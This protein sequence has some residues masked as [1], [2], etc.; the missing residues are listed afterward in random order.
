MKK[1]FFCFVSLA[2][3]CV[4]LAFSQVYIDAS[5]YEIASDSLESSP[6]VDS[7]EREIFRTNNSI[8]NVK[9]MRGMKRVSIDG[10]QIDP[11]EEV[12]RLENQLK[13]LNAKLA[14]AKKTL[15]YEDYDLLGM[16]VL[17]RLEEITKAS[18]KKIVLCKTFDELE[19]I[20]QE[21]ISFI[22]ENDGY[23]KNI[24]IDI[25]GGE[26]KYEF[27]AS[28]DGNFSYDETKPEYA[29]FVDFCARSMECVVSFVE[30]K[31]RYE[32]KEQNPYFV[33]AMGHKVQCVRGLDDYSF[34]LISFD[35]SGKSQNAILYDYAGS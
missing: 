34:G 25:C 18:G 13:E 2:L 27:K 17:E 35:D 24:M 6:E 12:I 1:R 14:D 23:E 16:R 3:F 33:D 7:I 31:K 10:R 20:N 26:K 4:S 22:L 19:E 9:M 5:I 8:N 21:Y 29:K 32:P 28:Y 30:D 11:D 15:K